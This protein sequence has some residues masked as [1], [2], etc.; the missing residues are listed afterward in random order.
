MFILASTP[1]HCL[2]TFSIQLLIW[3][4]HRVTHSFCIEKSVFDLD[5]AACYCAVVP[6]RS[7][8]LNWAAHRDRDQTKKTEK[9]T[10]STRAL[11]LW[12]LL[13][14]TCNF[15]VVRFVSR[16]PV[17]QHSDQIG[18]AA[19]PTFGCNCSGRQGV[20]GRVVWRPEFT[21]GCQVTGAGCNTS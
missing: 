8:Y 10:V 12:L 13:P 5:S 21:E 20:G 11:S 4:L 15:T 17:I 18:S 9:H 16:H 2:Y 3:A 19:S 6:L 14:S 1:W 7:Q